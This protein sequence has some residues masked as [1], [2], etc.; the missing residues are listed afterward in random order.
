MRHRLCLAVLA[1]ALATALGFGLAWH[2][3]DESRATFE[4]YSR[5][6]DQCRLQPDGDLRLSCFDGTL[7]E[8]PGD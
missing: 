3:A 2:S 7:R 5:L 8:Q 4:D 6:V 1:A